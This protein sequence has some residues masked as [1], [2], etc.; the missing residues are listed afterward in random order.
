MTIFAG[1]FSLN[2][3]A[4]PTSLKESLRLNL[5]SVN[6]L[7]GESQECNQDSFFLIK[8]DSGAFSESAWQLKPDG[9]VCTL[10]GDPLLIENS[11]RTSRAQQLARLAPASEPLDGAALAMCRGSFALVRYEA[12]GQSLSL[13]TDAVGLRSIYYVFQ[14]GVLFFSTAL[15]VLE[16]IPEIEKKLSILGMA[17]QSAFSFPLA[18][19][20]PYEGIKVLRECEILMASGAGISSRS[21]YDWTTSET[22]SNDPAEAAKHLHSIFQE[23]IRIRAG[24]DKRV[25]S[26]L[27]GGMDS[28]AIMATL[29]GMGRHVE[30]MNFSPDA[31]QDQRYAQLLAAEAKE[32]CRLHCLK[33]GSYPN[34]SFLA[35]AAKTELEQLELTSVDRPQ[36]IWSGDGGSVGLGHV[37]M[38]ERM[39]DLGES[40]DIPSAMKHFMDV[41]RI[42]IAHG[43]LR[44]EVRQYLPKMLFESVM[45]E[46]DRYQRMDIGR[47]IY[48]FLLFNDQRR[49]LFKH[50]ETI[51]QHGLELLTPFYDAQLLKAVSATPAR[52]GILHRLYDLFFQHLPSFALR[53]PWQTYPGHVPC[54]LPQDTSASYQWTRTSQPER[55]GI[56][57]RTKLARQL[58]LAFN[59]TMKPQVFSQSR[60]WLAALLH[61][62]GIRDCQHILSPLQIY[63]Q[64]YARAEGQEKSHSN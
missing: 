3:R 35:L 26:F 50:F 46:V 22:S 14:D 10:V 55:R 48:L 54:P 34:F 5:R 12:N 42:A 59:R 27:S 16:A 28:R 6:N 60:I 57:G 56:V 62:S 7:S 32:E 30:A 25:Y 51:D 39:L 53:T 52:W 58:L 31:S 4:L 41:N 13:T 61:A 21:Y 17:E 8:W 23:A 15:R 63:Q 40:G 29:I 2:T 44:N 36:L 37:Y 47:R 1:A 11:I 49:H 18:D 9:S 64:Y 43:V 33:G 45:S 38:N 20:T 24:E 19:R